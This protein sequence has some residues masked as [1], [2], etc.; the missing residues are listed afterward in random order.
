M[1]KTLILAGAAAL[2]FACNSRTNEPGSN[3][4]TGHAA[5]S[6]NAENPTDTNQMQAAMDRMMQKMHGIKSTGNIDIDFASMMLEH[7]KGAVEMAELEL[8]KGTDTQLKTFAQG[9]INDQNKEITFMKEFISNSPQTM[10]ANS[11]VFQK[12][13]ERSMMAMMKDTTKPYDNI[14]KDFA[15][16]MIPH[17]QSAVDMAKAYLEYGKHAELTTLSRNIIMSQ[18]KEI[19]WLNNWLAEKIKL[20]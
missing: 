20:R 18:S 4:D 10:S 3:T 9:V 11:A 13:L 17:H 12:A 7:H 1:K 14:D 19:T 6:M 2:I 8:A 16:G 15:A 5:H